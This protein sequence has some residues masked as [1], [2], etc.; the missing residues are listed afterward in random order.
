MIL[1]KCKED[2]VYW[3]NNFAF[4]FDPRQEFY[5]ERNLP[6]FLFDFQE[7]LVEWVDALLETRQDGVIEKSRDVGASYTLL[8]P[9]VLHHWLFREFN[10]KIGSRVESY[11]DKTDDPDSLFWKIDYNLKR[12]PKWMLP[13]GFD[14]SKHRT[15]MRLSRPDNEN[16]ITGESANENFARAGR[17][18]LVL[19]DELGFWPFAKSSWESAGESTTTRLAIST[20]APTGRSSFF[21]K[22]VQS[23]K[24]V[25]FTFH[26]T[27]DPRKDD[28]WVERQRA[29]KSG[30]EF[31]RELNI[32]YQGSLENTVYASQFNQCEIRRIQ[33]NPSLPL[34]ISWDFGLDGTA[35]Q[36]YQWNHSTDHWYLIDTYE[37]SNQDIE[38]FVPFITGNIISAHYVYSLKDIEKIREHKEWKA[39]THFGDPDVAKRSYQMGAISTQEI[40]NKHGIYVQTK[41]W[42]NKTHYDQ[43]QKTL[44]FLKKLSVDSE[45]NEYFIDCIRNAKYPE[46]SETSQ[47]TSPIKQPIHDWTSHHRSCLEYMADNAP[48]KLEEESFNWKSVPKLN[49]YIPNAL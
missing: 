10:A 24:A 25:K 44:L 37:N 43:K 29:K 11:V 39:A 23:G 2:P 22:L 27:K 20:P 42:A 32:S 14:F 19:F 30:E 12:L 1:E 15:Y 35:I 4:T 16:T 36:W 34:F 3:C 7:E 45:N 28:K 40:L 31:E 49:K 21:Y 17:S 48:D 38:Y 6:F 5:Q 8:V 47:S 18:N 9:I 41:S 13:E 46:R 26:Y 33:Y